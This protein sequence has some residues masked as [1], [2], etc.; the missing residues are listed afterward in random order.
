M[1]RVTMCPSSGENT[2]PMRRLVLVTLYRWLSGMQGSLHTRQSSIYSDKYQVSHKY[3]IF[4]WW[5][6][7]SC[8]KCVEKSNTYYPRI[9]LMPEHR[10]VWCSFGFPQTIE[11]NSLHTLS[12]LLFTDHRTYAYS[13]ITV[14]SINT[15]LHRNLL[16]LRMDVRRVLRRKIGYG[17]EM[18]S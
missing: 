1:F 4:S 15:P 13:E 14:P 17:M 18:Y 16:V 8:P 5:W 11:S 3:G 10:V 12:N 9:E 2:V 7:H 6:E